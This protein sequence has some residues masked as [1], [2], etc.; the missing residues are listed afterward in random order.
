MNELLAEDGCFSSRT[1]KNLAEGCSDEQVLNLIVEHSEHCVKCSARLTDLLREDSL[2]RRLAEYQTLNLEN[3]RETIRSALSLIDY[4]Q[5]LQRV[6]QQAERSV[7]EWDPTELIPQKLAQYQILGSIA[8]GGMG[9]VLH[10]YD[11]QL[12]RS[13]AIKI[14]RERTLESPA[15]HARFLREARAVA[16]LRNDHIMPVYQ[17]GEDEG[18]TFVV[19]PLLDGETLGSRLKRAEELNVSD[20]L[21][22]GME[23]AEALSAAHNAGVIHRDVKPSNIWLEQPGDRVKL[24]DF[25]LASISGSENQEL[26]LSGQLLGTPGYLAPEQVE[27]KSSSI[28]SDLFSMGCVLFEMLVGRAPFQASTVFESLKAV[29]ESPTPSI[30]SLKPGLPSELCDLVE[31]LLSKNPLA[32]PSSATEVGQRLKNLQPPGKSERL[33][34]EL[35]KSPTRVRRN[36][37]VWIACGFLATV[38][39]CALALIQELSIRY[40]DGRGK[41]VVIPLP[42]D[43]TDIRVVRPSLSSLATGTPLAFPVGCYVKSP[44]LVSGVDSWDMIPALQ[45]TGNR[46]EGLVSVDRRWLSLYGSSDQIVRVFD[47]QSG[48]L[49]RAFHHPLSQQ[50]CFSPDGLRVAC[51]VEQQL[52]EI[53]D[54]PEGRLLGT[55]K[56][57][58][59]SINLSGTG[60]VWITG[61]QQFAV[62]A[63]DQLVVINSNNGTIDDEIRLPTGT[64]PPYWLA[65]SPDGRRL[66]FAI[67]GS[68]FVIDR[69]SHELEVRIEDQD[70]V[71]ESHGW[72]LSWSPNGTQLVV[73]ALKPILIDTATW[74]VEKRL[75]V[76]VDHNKGMFWPSSSPGPYFGLDRLDLNTGTIAHSLPE[77]TKLTHDG[78]FHIRRT[79]TGITL[80]DI[81]TKRQRFGFSSPSGRRAMGTVYDSGRRAFVSGGSIVDLV[82]GTSI[83]KSDAST[84]GGRPLIVSPDQT[85]VIG[86]G[87]PTIVSL[88][89]GKRIDSNFDLYDWSPDSTKLVGRDQLRT[90]LCLVS[91]N[92]TDSQFFNTTSGDTY[93]AA[94]FGK[95][96]KTVFAYRSSGILE[97]WDSVTRQLIKEVPIPIE[98]YNSAYVLITDT[99]KDD[100]FVCIHF[101]LWDLTKSEKVSLTNAAIGWSD[102]ETKLYQ[103]YAGW[104]ETSWPEKK[105]LNESG[106]TAYGLPLGDFHRALG[107][108]W[109]NNGEFSIVGGDHPLLT[110]LEFSNGTVVGIN[111][112]GHFFSTAP[113]T[114]EFVYVV[115]HSGTQRCYSSSEFAEN[116]GFKLDRTRALLNR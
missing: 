78:G 50:V 56:F 83:G 4:Q 12:N 43:A 108:G 100:Q 46:F 54:I 21:R 110:L 97:V 2:S 32:R 104:I 72:P 25:G 113:I 87:L 52:I 94:R 79:T 27:G 61:T 19:M 10:G 105:L 31:Q 63:N 18:R 42:A 37:I 106:T 85:K 51:V 22:I 98:G 92:N 26:T 57:V 103:Y 101:Q 84:L 65:S 1:W 77:D 16:A 33:V 111:P 62:R 40:K 38:A 73:S 29:I 81:A 76:A 9:A 115:R 88:E 91:S 41:E 47:L 102:D 11:P 8:K 58:S 3:D 17:I 107:G 86:L 99:T 30:K 13:V 69:L 53:W 28:Q 109:L 35:P 80:T 6:V 20:V 23:L 75:D 90:S 96:G 59:P 116:T 114:S 89:T 39:L 36:R 7:S 24:L 60:M 68:L 82:S 93:I 74:R 45:E 112:E 48:T 49:S 67:S 44:A 14:M 71:V 70:L 64:Q 5:V 55:T 34:S 95:S 15:S 66:A